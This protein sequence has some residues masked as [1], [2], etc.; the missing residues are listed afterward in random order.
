MSLRTPL[1][2][3]PTLVVSV[4]G[5]TQHASHTSVPTL[6][7]LL[8]PAN[9]LCTSPKNS[10]GFCGTDELFYWALIIRSPYQ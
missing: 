6:Q 10:A 7:L 3:S 2:I 9:T 1:P 8:L 4:Y 5:A